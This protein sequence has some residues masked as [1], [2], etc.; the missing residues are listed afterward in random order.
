MLGLR[1]IQLT[2]FASAIG[3]IVAACLSLRIAALPA[4]S[5]LRRRSS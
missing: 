4:I 1:A 5:V 2:F 3:R